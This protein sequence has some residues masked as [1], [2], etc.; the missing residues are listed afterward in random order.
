MDSL[1]SEKQSKKVRKRIRKILKLLNVKRK[2]KKFKNGVTKTTA[3]R[4]A[5][6]KLYKEFLNSV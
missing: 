4:K 5:Y 2:S 1:F 3:V 6:K